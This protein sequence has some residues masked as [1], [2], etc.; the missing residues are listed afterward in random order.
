[1]ILIFVALSNYEINQHQK[2][3]DLRY[4]EY[5]CELSPN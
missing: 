3:P 5:T 1:M 4:V 2:F